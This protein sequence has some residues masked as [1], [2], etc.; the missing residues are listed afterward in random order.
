MKLVIPTG[1]LFDVG[2]SLSTNLSQQQDALYLAD[3]PWGID[4]LEE[5]VNVSSFIVENNDEDYDENIYQIERE[6]FSKRA[7]KRNH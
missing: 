2:F 5:N 3:G 4:Y 1:Q 6:A 7:S